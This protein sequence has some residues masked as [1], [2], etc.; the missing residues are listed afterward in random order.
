MAGTAV[1]HVGLKGIEPLEEPLGGKPW[2]GDDAGAGRQRREER[3]YEAVNVKQRHHVQAAV[4]VGQLE[5]SNAMLWAELQMFS[6]VKGT[7]LGRAVVPEVWSTSAVS[8]G[9]VNPAAVAEP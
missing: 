4:G 9:A 5:C 3:P 1:Y 2:R 6:C 8:S 7:I